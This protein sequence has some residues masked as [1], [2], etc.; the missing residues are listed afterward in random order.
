MYP[1]G[2]MCIV[3]GLDAKDTSFVLNLLFGW[4]IAAMD[5]LYSLV[6]FQYL[7]IDGGWYINFSFYT[8][9]HIWGY[10]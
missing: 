10:I 9:Q 6:S 1:L 7:Q 3:S 4:M 8:F 5:P 2:E